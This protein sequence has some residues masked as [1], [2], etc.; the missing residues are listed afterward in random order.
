MLSIVYSI[1]PIFLA[2][3][4]GV[5]LGKSAPNTLP[6]LAAKFI[7]PLVWLLLLSIG[8]QF[9]SIFED[10]KAAGRTLYVAAVFAG[11]T[12]LVPCVLMFGLSHKKRKAEKR[13]IQQDKVSL[14]APLKECALALGM[15]LMGIL[16]SLFFASINVNENA[17][18]EAAL[19]TD[20][21]LYSLIFL[22]GVDIVGVKLSSS[23]Y[24]LN[25]LI[26]PILVVLGSLLGGLIAAVFIKLP[27]TTGLALSS[28]FGWFTLSGVLVSAELGP[29]FGAIA[30][31]TDLFRELLAI[32][33]LYLFGREFSRECIAAGGATTLDSTL[34]IV[35][36]TCSSDNLLT[37]LVSGLLLTL[38]A[39]I[40][41]TFFLSISHLYP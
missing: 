39:P 34:P 13:A 25:I 29:A 35:K 27:F 19:L 9:G 11:L 38:L 15:L 32:I 3:T 36:Q 41:M 5:V 22:V 10:P 33:L 7:G 23:W 30:L 40:L 6:Q 20:I 18:F 24:S 16:L 37:A 14:L 21:L 26:I 12:T 8:I 31:M 17:F 2:L 1:L 28:G 4:G